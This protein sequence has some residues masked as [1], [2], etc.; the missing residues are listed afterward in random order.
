LCSRPFLLV[1]R[2]LHGG[3][4]RGISDFKLN[5]IDRG[6]GLFLIIARKSLG[7]S[8]PRQDADFPTEFHAGVF[9]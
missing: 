4:G 5:D 8:E 1:A 7:S 6:P 3:I 9:G 2:R